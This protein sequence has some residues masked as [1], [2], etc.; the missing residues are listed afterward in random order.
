MPSAVAAAIG[1]VD[2]FGG[3]G[4][5]VVGSSV[6]MIGSAGFRGPGCLSIAGN[7]IDVIRGG[8]DFDAGRGS[9]LDAGSG[10]A[11][12][13]FARAPPTGSTDGMTNFALP[14]LSVADFGAP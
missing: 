4:L 7:P 14:L 11:V 3:S 9:G 10:G 5:I 1:S 2:R 13:V 12:G 6:S 8:I